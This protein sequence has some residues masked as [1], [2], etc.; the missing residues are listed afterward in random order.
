MKSGQAA[1]II[2]SVISDS[3]ARMGICCAKLQ[4]IEQER[5]PGGIDASG[6][7]NDGT[8]ASFQTRKTLSVLWFLKPARIPTAGHVHASVVLG[9]DVLRDCASQLRNQHDAKRRAVEVSDPI[10][11]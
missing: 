7:K 8:R 5:D 2:E 11:V 9:D 10:D 4:W 3:A 1:A 6:T